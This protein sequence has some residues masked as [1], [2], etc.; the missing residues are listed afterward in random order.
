MTWKAA[1]DGAPDSLILLLPGRTGRPIDGPQDYTTRLVPA[2]S[3]Q[4]DEE[5]GVDGPAKE[6]IE[7][8]PLVLPG[9]FRYRGVQDDPARDEPQEGRRKERAEFREHAHRPSGQR[10]EDERIAG[11]PVVPGS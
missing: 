10:G 5:N 6:K 11:R 1:R 2:G 3:R 4:D 8:P 9:Q 7:R